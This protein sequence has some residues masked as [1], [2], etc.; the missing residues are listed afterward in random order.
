MGVII[1]NKER[2]APLLTKRIRGPS[3]DDHGEGTRAR[4]VCVALRPGGHGR[5]KR[6]RS[7]KWG[8]KPRRLCHLNDLSCSQSAV[9]GPRGDDHGKGAR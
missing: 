4:G 7:W 3:G 9:L 8:H 2:L 5:P 6:R 1:E